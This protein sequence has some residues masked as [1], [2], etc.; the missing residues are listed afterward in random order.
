[1]NTC[2]KHDCVVVYT[3]HNCPMCDLEDQVEILSEKIK[4]KETRIEELNGEIDAFNG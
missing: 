4:E 3:C 2:E 1:M